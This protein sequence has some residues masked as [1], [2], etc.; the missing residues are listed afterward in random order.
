MKSLNGKETFSTGE[1][2]LAITLIILGFQLECID[3]DPASSGRCFFLF[4]RSSENGEK[5]DEAVQAFWR[6][7][8]RVAPRKFYEVSRELKSRIRENQMR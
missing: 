1:F 8:I 3:R 2:P 4:D 7:E 6:D 5:L